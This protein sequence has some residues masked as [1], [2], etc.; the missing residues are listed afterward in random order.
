[1]IMLWILSLFGLFFLVFLAS[2][3]TQETHKFLLRRKRRK[4]DF[5]RSW[6]NS[7]S[8]YNGR[9][10]LIGYGSWDENDMRAIKLFL[11]DYR[12]ATETCIGDYFPNDLKE[13]IER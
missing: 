4:E 5:K 6:K 8:G 13:L 10:G 1:M 3:A 12:K 7:A 9:Y 2:I 11:L